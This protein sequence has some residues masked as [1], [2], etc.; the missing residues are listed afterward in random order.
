MSAQNDKK[1]VIIGAGPAG[2][3]A[4]Y[5]L[6]KEG[7]NSTVLEKDTLVGGISKTVD[8]KGYHF[9]IGGHRF[10]SKVKEIN[11]MWHEVLRGD[12]LHCNRLS[13][14]YYRKK[15]FYYP[16]RPRNV[17]SNLGL[18]NSFLIVSSY[19]Y[20]HVFPEKPANNFE[21]WVSNRFGKRLYNI[22]FKSYTEKVWGVPCSQ[23]SSEWAAQRIQG[24]SL[25]S[26]LRNAF[27]KQN[28]HKRSSVIKSLI[29]TFEYPKKG[30][31]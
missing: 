4:A 23:I 16:L 6:C 21:Q 27:E 2:L 12:M 30:L 11:D 19:I 13:R 24:L 14:I 1:V 29:N 8:H 15:F 5:E 10:F 25:I 28:E 22:F 31:V 18:W 3:T 7:I 17:L 26:T 9:D 20:S